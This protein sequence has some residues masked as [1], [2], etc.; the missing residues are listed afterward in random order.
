MKTLEIR[1][2]LLKKGFKMS[3]GDHHNYYL[4][5]EGK[6]TSVRTKISHNDTDIGDPLIRAMAQQL[7]LSKN[8]FSEYVAC[9]LCL[10][11]YYEILRQNKNL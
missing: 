4:Y 8:E 5:Y 1:R 7:K 6:K 2:A 3:E 11:K 10:E 9:T